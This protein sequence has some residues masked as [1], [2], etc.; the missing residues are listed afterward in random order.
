[1]TS[2]PAL[3]IGILSLAQHSLTMINAISGVT[4]L[5]TLSSSSLN[6]LVNGFGKVMA[7]SG[8]QTL[9]CDITLSPTSYKF[10][11]ALPPEIGYLSGVTSAVQ[12]QSVTYKC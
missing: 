4:S 8:P 10:P 1:M 6:S 9:T 7:L 3:T 5:V 11:G 2:L 12:T